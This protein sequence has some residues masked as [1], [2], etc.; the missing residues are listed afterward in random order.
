MITTWHINET[1]DEVIQF[2]EMYKIEGIDNQKIKI[3]QI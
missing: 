1:L 3:I 2:A